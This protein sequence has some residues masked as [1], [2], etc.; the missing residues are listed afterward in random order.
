[1]TRRLREEVAMERG[2]GG[3]MVRCAL[4]WPSMRVSVE[5]RVVYAVLQWLTALY[6]V[7]LVHIDIDRYPTF[8]A[9]KD[10]SSALMQAL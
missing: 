8:S 10:Q 7:V 6:T 1:M 2:D 3:G 9:G 4:R 5:S